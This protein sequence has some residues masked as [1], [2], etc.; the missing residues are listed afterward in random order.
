MAENKS[1]EKIQTFIPSSEI[2]ESY[3]LP[4]E[5]IKAIFKKQ[6]DSTIFE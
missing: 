2:L 4:Q 6:K 5:L 3:F 1:D